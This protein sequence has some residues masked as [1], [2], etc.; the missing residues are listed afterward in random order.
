MNDTIIGVL[1]GFAGAVIPSI[2]SLIFGL[3]RERNQRKHELA[4]WRLNAVETARMEALREY[5]AQY[6]ALLHGVSSP[7]FSPARYIAALERAAIYVQPETLK[8]M[9]DAS[10]PVLKDWGTTAVE[11]REFGSNRMN[12]LNRLLQ[13]EMRLSSEQFN[14]KK[15]KKRKR[16][17]KP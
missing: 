3:I 7:E 11:N 8:A 5:A 15:P 6:G 1:I 17:T 12:S 4:M 16:R 9:M 2:L 10:E 13:D 14:Q